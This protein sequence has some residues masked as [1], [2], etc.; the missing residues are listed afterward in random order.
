[1]ANKYLEK[2]AALNP[3]A[4]DFARKVVSSLSGKPASTINDVYNKT[5]ATIS[6]RLGGVLTGAEKSSVV[7]RI[8][9]QADKS[10]GVG[11]LYPFEATRAAR[12][13]ARLA[14]MQ[15]RV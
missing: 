14:R 11:R 10:L 2:I 6:P 8:G 4:K 7:S 15:N 12:A 3:I 5:H 9:A 1:M 13:G